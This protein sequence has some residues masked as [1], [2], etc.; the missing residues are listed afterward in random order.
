[1]TIRRSGECDAVL[2]RYGLA[3]CPMTII[4]ADK[5]NEPSVWGVTVTCE[6][7]RSEFL[8]VVQA[9]KLSVELRRIGEDGLAR[10]LASAVEAAKRQMRTMK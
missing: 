9:D 2:A 6:A 4:G 5:R 3:D 7:G 1:M 10:R 8:D